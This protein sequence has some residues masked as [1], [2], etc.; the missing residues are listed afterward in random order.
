MYNWDD[1]P[2]DRKEA[3]THHAKVT[4]V[5]VIAKPHN[6]L[7]INSPWRDNGGNKVAVPKHPAGVCETHINRLLRFMVEHTS[8]F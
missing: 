8:D 7:K 1:A 6:L 3:F 4:E 5:V 2:P